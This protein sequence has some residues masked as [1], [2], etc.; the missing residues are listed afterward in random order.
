MTIGFARLLVFLRLRPGYLTACLQIVLY[1]KV[2][3]QLDGCW[4]N[5]VSTLLLLGIHSLNVLLA[6]SI[7]V[8]TGH[9]SYRYY[10][11]GHTSPHCIILDW[12]RL[13]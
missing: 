6:H 2:S 5:T 12:I 7:A 10:K 3:H 11:P 4:T 1:D 9:R 13:D 8:N